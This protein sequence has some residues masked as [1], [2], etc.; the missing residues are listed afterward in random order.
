MDIATLFTIIGAVASVLA[1][2]IAILIATRIPDKDVLSHRQ[3]IRKMVKEL[4]FQMKH[5][6]R[7]HMVRII[8]IDRF[9][10]Y[11]P[12]VFNKHC[13]QSY[14]KGELDGT[15]IKGINIVNGLI[16]VKP[17]SKNPSRFVLSHDSDAIKTV[18][19]GLIPYSWIIDIDIDGDECESSAIFYCKFKKHYPIAL[20][21]YYLSPEPGG[22]MQKQFGFVRRQSPYQ[23]NK[24]YIQNETSDTV[25]NG[26][27]YS[28]EISVDG[29]NPV[30]P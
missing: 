25:S 17:S 5:N 24:Y 1:V 22:K 23:S 2:I 11:Y 29:D 19:I 4:Y 21:H 9:D 20:R 7:N 18:R 14:L 12:E 8:D 26:S 16:G 10:K 3:H 13:V 28:N 30:Y 15:D 27:V 6:G